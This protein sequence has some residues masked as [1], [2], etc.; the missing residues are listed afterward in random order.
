MIL[1]DTLYPTEPKFCSIS[2]T[3]LPGNSLFLLGF[4]RNS[5]AAWAYLLGAVNMHFVPKNNPANKNQT[6]THAKSSDSQKSYL[7]R[8]KTLDIC[9]NFFNHVESYMTH[10]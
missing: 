8:Q 7:E 3:C 2:A 5:A 9:K 1:T 4:A 10:S 6:N